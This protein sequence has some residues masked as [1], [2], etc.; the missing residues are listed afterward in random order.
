[1]VVAGCQAIMEWKFGTRSI[2]HIVS[3]SS[4]GDICGMSL[5]LIVSFVTAC[6]QQFSMNTMYFVSV[7]ANLC[8]RPLAV[9]ESPLPLNM[10]LPVNIIPVW[11]IC[12][13]MNPAALM[14][15]LCCSLHQSG[16]GKHV[17]QFPAGM[18]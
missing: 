12:A 4:V 5:P 17:L 1:M 18:G 7:W 11:I 16:N 2:Q 15:H 13:E 8:V 10:P 6:R 9:S 3:I 14:S